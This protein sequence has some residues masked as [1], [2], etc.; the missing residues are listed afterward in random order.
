MLH[1][2]IL[3]FSIR[4]SLLIFHKRQ[5]LSYSLFNFYFE[6][7]V[8]KIFFLS[9]VIEEFNQNG[10]CKLS[11]N[12]SYEIEKIKN[13]FKEKNKI[14]LAREVFDTDENSKKKLIKLLEKNC[15]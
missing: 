9:N 13:H 5:P 3:Y 11:L 2:I 1:R 6:K 8:K 4:I 12:L 15:H 14:N 7:D 10:Y